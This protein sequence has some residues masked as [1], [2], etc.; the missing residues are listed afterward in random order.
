[1]LAQ[2]NIMAI[3]IILTHVRA[4][5][6]GTISTVKR[7]PESPVNRA[8]IKAVIADIMLGTRAEYCII[9]TLITSIENTAAAIGVPKSAEKQALIP[10]MIVIFVSLVSYFAIFA[11]KFPNEP[12]ICN[13]APSLPAEPP[14][15]WVRA[16]LTIM[17]GVIR[18]GTRSPD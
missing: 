5:K 6:S 18:N 1:M 7:V 11:K 14:V 12:P 15:R 10:H 17:R 3:R 13:A 16:V 8:I 4:F 9:P 2:A